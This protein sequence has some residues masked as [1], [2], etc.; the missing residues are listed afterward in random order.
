MS[1]LAP[2]S[3]ASPA[4]P[5]LTLAPV[6]PLS[7]AE[8]QAK[9]ATRW[10]LWFGSPVLVM[11]VF[12]GAAFATGASSLLGGSLAA[13]IADIGVLIWLCMSSDTNGLIGN[14]PAH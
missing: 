4:Q 2:A 1:A 3:Y 7:A 6:V 10:M 14:A 13:L 11:V 9:E 8:L 5:A 12:I